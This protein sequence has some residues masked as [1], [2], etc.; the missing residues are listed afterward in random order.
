MSE[1]TW[2]STDDL[3]QELVHEKQVTTINIISDSPLSQFRNKTTIYL[4][5]QFATKEQVD[6][7]WIFLESGHGKGVADAVGAAV[8]RNF[9]Q[10]ISYK[11]DDSFKNAMDLLDA[12]ENSSN[13]KLFIYDKSDI[14]K[15]KK[16]IP[17]L[18]AIKGTA[19]FHEIIATKDGA[20][21]AKNLSSEKEKQ[22]KVQF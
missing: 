8:K 6:V 7:K 21:Y 20:L 15:V 19:G 2:A 14:E 16:S 1:A 10:A 18:V 17:K 12:V 3:L 11:P 9:D 22:L 5:K 4:M 13:I